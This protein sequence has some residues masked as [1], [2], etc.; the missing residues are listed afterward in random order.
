M[1]EYGPLNWGGSELD[2]ALAVGRHITLDINELQ[3]SAWCYWQ[4]LE[5][6]GKNFYWGLLHAEFKYQAN[7]SDPFRVQIKKQYYMM[8]HFSRWI[9]PGFSIHVSEGQ[10]RDWLM[11]AVNLTKTT[12]VMV[13][14][15]TSDRNIDINFDVS[16]V[17]PKL[18]DRHVQAAL[19]RTSETES[20]KELPTLNFKTSAIVVRI[21]AKCIT[22]IVVSDAN[23]ID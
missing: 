22:T 7:H 9:R 1:S 20:H 3:A 4:V 2:V 23:V 14:N 8:M 15:N 6:L 19:I 10:F 18:K 17:A 13:F 12:V 21:L 11:L 5:V 16:G